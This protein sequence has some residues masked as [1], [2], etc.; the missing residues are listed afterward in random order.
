M[1][2]Q[3]DPRER[4]RVMFGGV[5]ENAPLGACSN[6]GWNILP[7]SVRVVDPRHYFTV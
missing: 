3:F 5:I 7:A 4:R 2:A 1:E 6:G